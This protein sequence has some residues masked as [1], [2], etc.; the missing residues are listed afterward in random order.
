MKKKSGS[1]SVF[2]KQVLVLLESQGWEVDSQ[3]E[4]GYRLGKKSKYRVDIVAGNDSDAILISCK[5]Q[6]SA[7]TAI[8]KIP[9][10]YMSLLHAVEANRLSAAYLVVFGKEL[11]NH[12]FLNEGLKELK[13]YMRMDERVKILTFEEFQSLIVTGAIEKRESK[14]MELTC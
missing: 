9:Y 8:D 4:L 1:G 11:S 3:Y 7:G 2:E 13:N 6:D 10:E 12:Y 5:Y 14:Q